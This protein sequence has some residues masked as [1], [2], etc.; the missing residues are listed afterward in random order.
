[1]NENQKQ[2]VVTK[3]NYIHIWLK[4]EEGG[5]KGESK[6]AH[7]NDWCHKLAHSNVVNYTWFQYLDLEDDSLGAMD[8]TVHAVR[9]IREI[10]GELCDT[11]K[12]IAQGDFIG[13]VTSKVG[14]QASCPV[15]KTVS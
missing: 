8:K 4:I 6:M 5:V 9:A 14:G 11:T 7:K 12:E 15:S 10:C 3:E 2:K 1:M 13:A